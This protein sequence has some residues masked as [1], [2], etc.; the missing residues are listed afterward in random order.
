MYDDEIKVDN[1]NKTEIEKPLLV[2]I[3]N[4][5][6]WIDFGFIILIIA[7]FS[8]PEFFGIIPH[9]DLILCLISLGVSV[10]AIV[11]ARLI[12]KRGLNKSKVRLIV[13]YVIW[14]IW[15]PLDLFFIVRALVGIFSNS[16]YALYSVCVLFA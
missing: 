10:S 4:I 16:A 7:Y 13:R 2:R 8:N 12:H 1:A 11:T 5:I 6:D 3:Y 9:M 15:I 14:G